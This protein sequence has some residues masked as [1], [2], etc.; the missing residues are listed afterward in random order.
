MCGLINEVDRSKN[1]RFCRKKERF[2]NKYLDYYL[3]V[4]HLM[5]QKLIKIF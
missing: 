5:I 2:C 4:V 3:S 1:K